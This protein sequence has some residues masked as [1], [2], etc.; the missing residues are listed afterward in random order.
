M[1]HTVLIVGVLAVLA[2]LGGLAY[3]H[4]THSNVNFVDINET[5]VYDSWVHWK[6]RHNRLY[7]DAEEKQRFSIYRENYKFVMTHNQLY[8]NGES[9]FSV[10]LN[11]FAD[12][13]NEEFRASRLGMLPRKEQHQGSF[14][15]SELPT[16]VDWR[17]KAVS[18]VK[19]QGSC[20][21]CWAFSTTGS[22]EGLH[23]IQNGNVET[24]SEQ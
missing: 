8:E 23:A 19:N 11:D 2:T 14:W 17:G 16:S 22:L 21:S 4:E 13:T 10:A 15:V 1:N 24:Y 18:D 9:T 6:N 5:A 3:Y 20:G 12:L 7:N